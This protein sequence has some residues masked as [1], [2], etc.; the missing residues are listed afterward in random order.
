[1][2]EGHSHIIGNILYKPLSGNKVCSGT[3]ASYDIHLSKNGKHSNGCLH[4]TMHYMY[5][6]Q[7]SA[8]PS[9]LEKSGN[10]EMNALVRLYMS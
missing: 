4:I 5:R 8:D 2:G 1:M 9:S 7:S 6:L 3:T 10:S